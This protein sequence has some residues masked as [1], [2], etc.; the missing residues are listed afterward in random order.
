[1]NSHACV[2]PASAFCRSGRSHRVFRR[3]K[4]RNTP[5]AHTHEEFSVIVKA[6]YEQAFPLFGAHEERKWAKGFDPLFVHPSPARDQ[7]GMVFTWKLGGDPS[8][9][10]NTAFDP[11]S[12]HVQYVYFVND[13]M[14]TLIDIHLTKAGAAETRVDVVY[15]RTA[16]RPEANELVTQQAKADRNRGTE[17]A[18]MINGYLT[19][20][21]AEEVIRANENLLSGMKP[22]RPNMI[23]WT[24]TA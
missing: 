14:V 17:W 2:F 15:E 5:L 21:A 8:V 23:Q 1:M 20:E 6:P 4:H 10:T 18:E 22:A 11:A 19:R 16:L 9:W 24:D 3:R 12:G 7:Q 13:T